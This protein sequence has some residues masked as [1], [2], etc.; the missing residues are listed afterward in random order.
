M[1]RQYYPLVDVARSMACKR[2][3]LGAMDARYR[4]PDFST[5]GRL[6][7]WE[8]STTR[9]VKQ[10]QFSPVR[11]ISGLTHRGFLEKIQAR[12]S[13]TPKQPDVFYRAGRSHHERT[14]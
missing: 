6:R 11:A 10:L 8:G 5:N 1:N 2:E 4:F 3:S 12:N 9:E 14:V 13:P 7:G